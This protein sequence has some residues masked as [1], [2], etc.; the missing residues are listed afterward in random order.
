MGGIDRVNTDNTG[1][2]RTSV[3]QQR[4]ERHESFKRC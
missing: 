1:N 4:Q 2:R 3:K